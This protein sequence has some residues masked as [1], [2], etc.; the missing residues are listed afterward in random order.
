MRERD[1]HNAAAGE[2]TT[3][4]L[5][6]LLVCYWKA[7]PVYFWKT[8]HFTAGG[9]LIEVTGDQ[10]LFYA[11]TDGF[12]PVC[13][14][15]PAPRSR[16]TNRGQCMVPDQVVFAT[17]RQPERSALENPSA[18]R[19]VTKHTGN[20]PIAGFVKDLC[21]R[22][23]K[24][25]TQ[26][27]KWESFSE[28]LKVA[29]DHYERMQQPYDQ[30]PLEYWWLLG[31][32]NDFES[33]RL[34][35]L[36]EKDEKGVFVEPSG[37]HPI[38]LYTSEI[39]AHDAAARFEKELSSEHK[40]EPGPITCLPCYI[41]SIM[42]EDGGAEAFRGGAILNDQWHIDL[43]LGGKAFEDPSA[44]PATMLDSDNSYALLGCHDTGGPFWGEV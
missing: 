39:F 42:Q 11:L 18:W 31:G 40:L 43:R 13:A 7:Y 36:Y 29:S 14:S 6:E 28:F 12:I 9:D 25:I 38:P 26:Y 22:Y 2:E 4:I 21:S 1:G 32:V 41:R 16:I 24:L 34:V 20:S 37:D 5:N 17:I 19:V 33:V 15:D 23:Q 8:R 30:K 10:R 35:G 3:E 27:G 44:S